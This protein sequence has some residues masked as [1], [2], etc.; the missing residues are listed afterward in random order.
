MGFLSFSSISF[1][2]AGAV[3]AVGPVLIH[4]LNRRR[5]RVV[6]WAAMDFLRQAMKQN[7]KVL[8]WRD[9]LLLAMRTLAVLLFGTALARPF[10]ASQQV[11]IDVRQPLHAVLI[12]D[13][14]L[15]MA[16][17]TLEGSLLEQAKR[18][19]REF[20]EQLPRG[21]RVSV[22]AAG[23]SLDYVHGE[24]LDT[25]E[26]AREA[27]SRIEIVDRTA[28]L[29]RVLELARLACEAAPELAKRIVFIGDQQE[30]NW[31][32]LPSGESAGDL[33]PI[34]CVVVRPAEWE[35]TW[36]AALRVQDGLADVETPTTV[37]VEVAHQGVGPR[38]DLPV[39]LTSGETI[40]GQQIVTV[41]PGG[42]REV[43][44]E[45]VLGGL[46]AAPEAA[47]VSFLP[48]TAKIGADRLTADDRRSLA[49]PVVA[50]LNVVFVDQYAKGQEDVTRGRLGETRALRKL[51]AP[52]GAQQDALRQPIKIRHLAPESLNRE[53][54]ADARLVVVAGLSD[55][56][57][58]VP[59][60]A[61]Y[62]QQ[63]GQLLIAAGA[64]FDPSAWNATAW[65]GGQG[66]LPLPLKSELIGVTPEEAPEKL[67]PFQLSFASLADEPMF[68]L[69][70]VSRQDLQALYA[71]PF[72]F[73]AVAVDESAEALAAIEVAEVVRIEDEQNR[74]ADEV[75]TPWLSWAEERA[76]SGVGGGKAKLPQILARYD[77]A[78]NP[79]FL[80]SRAMRRGRVL[81]CTSG[82]LS[83][84]NTL[85][86]TNAVLLFDQIMRGMIESTLPECNLPPNEHWTLQ[87]PRAEQ[88][89]AVSLL[90]PGAA[91]EEPLD[92][93]YVSAE[94]R[95]VVVNG[96][97][98]RGVYAV[99]G[100]RLA[101]STQVGQE[102]AV[103][104]LPLAVNGEAEESDLTPLTRSKFDE[105]AKGMSFRWVAAG[106]EIEL[107]GAVVNGQ[108]TWWWVILVVVVLLAAEMVVIVMPSVARRDS[109]GSWGGG[110]LAAQP[111]T[112]NSRPMEQRGASIS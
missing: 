103:W 107:A 2:V 83:S 109:M 61:D 70:G 96:L 110:R 4:L 30:L 32:M 73:K 85:P 27:L 56:A 12:I 76:S 59:V 77:G 24:A 5:H 87:L 101:G 8:E 90:R 58:M 31:R 100:R 95:G 23:G 54:L 17:E 34:Q 22:I 7:R 75:T 108:G 15:S 93:T 11:A 63:G 104:E 49:V 102:A 91:V 89:L 53:T 80:V 51:L 88:H 57:G 71:E 86:K 33:P 41:E 21:S 99:T 105:N 18:K 9:F 26:E 48:L 92:V 14:S 62:V 111:G 46:G 19:G 72:F 68:Q 44:F 52:P 29:T 64:D 69:A 65:Q 74:D 39:S 13:N 42:T 6:K 106:E 94:R 16:Y 1:L 38:R 25:L 20:I 3:C 66:I 78:G 10:F 40:L 97:L 37:I 55:P 35:N 112:V 36:V 43:S 47:Q 45:C 60:L 98:S 50:A 28:S 79:A 67:A 81:F 84:W 82:V